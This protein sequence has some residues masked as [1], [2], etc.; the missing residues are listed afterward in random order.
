[1]NAPLNGRCNGN[2]RP[3]P[4]GVSGNPAGKPP[5]AVNARARALAILDKILEESPTREALEASLRRYILRDP[6]RAFRTLVMPLLPKEAR[7][8]VDAAPRKVVWTS[9][10]DPSPAPAA[11]DDDARG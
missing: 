8:E 2:L 1:M 6:V 9:F 7:L 4:P 11:P 5:G 3:W 10:L